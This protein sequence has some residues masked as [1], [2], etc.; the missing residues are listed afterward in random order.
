MK[1]YKER[2]DVTVEGNKA[3]I[4]IS[5]SSFLRWLFTE[6]YNLEREREKKKQYKKYKNRV[7]W[8]VWLNN[9][10]LREGVFF[11]SFSPLVCPDFQSEAADIGSQALKLHH[12]Q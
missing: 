4:R 3:L 2:K 11:L 8:F 12:I 7:L 1:K 9:R 10:F 6:A 5:K